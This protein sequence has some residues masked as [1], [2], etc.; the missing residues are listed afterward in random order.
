MSWKVIR[1]ARKR[2]KKGDWGCNSYT[3]V[4]SGGSGGWNSGKRGGKKRKILG[5]GSG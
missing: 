5:K 2:G 1:K 3:D 4:R